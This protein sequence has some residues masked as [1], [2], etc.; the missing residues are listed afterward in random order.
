MQLYKLQEA[1]DALQR[2]PAVGTYWRHK[3]AKGVYAIKD[4]T[5]LTLPDRFLYSPA[6]VYHVPTPNPPNSWTGPLDWFL[7]Q[8]QEISA[9]DYQRYRTAVED[10]DDEAVIVL[11]Q[12]FDK[13][14][15]T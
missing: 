7:E 1:K 13:V 12:E 6:V 9:E 3:V 4:C 14:R 11:H 2:C 5:I 8:F 15:E 10:E